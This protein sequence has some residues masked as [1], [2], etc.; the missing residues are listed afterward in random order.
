MSPRPLHPLYQQ[1]NYRD[2]LALVQGRRFDRYWL[3]ILFAFGGDVA[4]FY[5]VLARVLQVNEVLTYIAM[6][7]VAAVAIALSHLVGVGWRQRKAGD[8]ARNDALTAAWLVV[9]LAFGAASFVA[10]IYF[11]PL[12]GGGT[13]GGDQPAEPAGSAADVLAA[14]FFIA[15]YV[16]SGL[17]TMGVSY[18][19]HNP[20]A[21]AFREAGERLSSARAHET[22]CA[23]AHATAAGAAEALRAEV[24]KA[25]Q[26]RE[27]ARV[28]TLNDAVGLKLAARQQM[29]R[30]IPGDDGTALPLFMDGAPAVH[31]YPAQGSS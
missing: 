10:R 26:R 12:T 25:G 17:L 4:A 24:D 21:I 9:W 30:N 22:A 13:F 3:V 1:G 5:I 2:L 16:A 23:K 28:G 20:A 11:G 8:P 27:Q 31:E 6:I 18:R 7:G 19:S 14:V 29:A 15:L